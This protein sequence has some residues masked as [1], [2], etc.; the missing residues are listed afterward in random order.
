MTPA[1]RLMFMGNKTVVFDS[2]SRDDSITSLGNAETGQTWDASG[3]WGISSGK[4]CYISGVGDTITV[5]DSGLSDA[6]VSVK[7]AV[8]VNGTRLVFRAESV[9]SCY[10]LSYSLN[11]HKLQL[12]K[13]EAGWVNLGEYVA[14]PVN[15]DMLKAVLNGGSIKCYLNDTLAIEVTDDFNKTSTKHGLGIATST[16]ARW[17]DFKVEAI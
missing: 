3:T 8:V 17:D 11:Q 16:D 6:V 9:S 1:K 12:F 2:F 15:G 7:L 4:A 5:V 10:L 13:R 14:D